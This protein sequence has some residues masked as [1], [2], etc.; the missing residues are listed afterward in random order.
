[1]TEVMA[2]NGHGD[3]HLQGYDSFD[4]RS[5]LHDKQAG[6]DDGFDEYLRSREFRDEVGEM[7]KEQ[8]QLSS[9]FLPSGDIS[10]VTHTNG[11]LKTIIPI[12]DIRGVD[13]LN[14]RKGEKVLRCKLASCYR[15]FDIYSLSSGTHSYITARLGSD[16]MLIT[17]SGLLFNEVTASSLTKVNMSG[18]VVDSGS[19]SLDVCRDEVSLHSA[20]YA[21]RDNVN[22]V[23]HVA[24]PSA[25]MVSMMKSGLLPL[26]YEA[27]VLGEIT[28]YDYSGSAVDQEERRGLK[29]ALGSTSQVLFVRNFG[30]V[31]VGETVEETY[32]IASN[33]MTATD[34]QVNLIPIGVHNMHLPSAQVQQSAYNMDRDVPLG[35]D[36]SARL[37]YGEMEFE[38]LMRQL[39]NDGYSTGYIYRN[40]AAFRMQRSVSVA[41]SSA[42]GGRLSVL[43]E[44]SSGIATPLNQLLMRGKRP[45]WVVSPN[46]YWKEEEDLVDAS[47]TGSLKGKPKKIYRWKSM[48]AMSNKPSQRSASVKNV[49][50]NKFAPQGANPKELREKVKEIRKEYF[51]DTITAGPQST[52]LEGVTWEEARRIKEGQPMNGIDNV[53]VTAASRGIIQREHQRDALFYKNY[54]LSNPFDH[55]TKDDL[56]KYHRE[57]QR[58][59]KKGYGAYAESEPEFLSERHIMTPVRASTPPAK[60]SR[61]SPIQQE[62]QQVQPRQLYSAGLQTEEAELRPVA[63]QPVLAEQP[64]PK[65]L[66]TQNQPE[67]A[68]NRAGLLDAPAGHSATLDNRSSKENS[69]VKDGSLTKEKKKK[70]GLPVLLQKEGKTIAI[71]WL[72]R[73][74]ANYLI[75]LNIL[76]AFSWLFYLPLYI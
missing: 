10:G 48:D 2:V 74:L 1:M 68:T 58:K 66:S 52:V 42:H 46:T 61:M 38:G 62:Y 14:Y 64:Q 20:L 35:A 56:E 25:V 59:S 47:N 26:C 67:K 39:D 45:E 12:S 63:R 32:C 70:K 41:D 73:K 6:G 15:L 4:D 24:S 71:L 31:V 65:A 29:Q 34:A 55:I 37:G 76:H 43:D 23:V 13:A 19:T 28:Y 7:V 11:P 72:N 33:V 9:T 57:V 75:L 36:P 21:A 69:P 8:L 44:R 18:N 51:E 27:M 17:P 16:Q 54:T 49:N 22:C 30:A 50:Q 40:P 53:R 60:P 5:A 3:Q